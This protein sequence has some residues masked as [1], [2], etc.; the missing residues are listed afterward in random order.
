MERSARAIGTD[1]TQEAQ[2]IFDALA[3]TMPCEWRKQTIEVYSEIEVVP[4]YTLDDCRF[5]G[6]SKGNEMMMDRA[7]TV[8][9]EELKRQAESKGA[10]GDNDDGAPSTSANGSL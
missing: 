1:V 7:K 10:A 6:G 3:K 4:P 2:D 8:L 5:I 9:A